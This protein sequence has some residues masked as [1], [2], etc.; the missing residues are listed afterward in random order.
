MQIELHYEFLLSIWLYGLRGNDC[1][2]LLSS[3]EPN[4]SHQNELSNRIDQMIICS[5]G[6][7]FLVLLILFYYC[8]PYLEIT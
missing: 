1:L 3:W 2:T 7:F 6:R 5:F 4:L 8:P